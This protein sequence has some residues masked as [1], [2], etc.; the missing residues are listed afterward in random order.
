MSNPPSRIDSGHRI[1]FTNFQVVHGPIVTILIRMT[2]F[3]VRHPLPGSRTRQIC[4]KINIC[5]ESNNFICK[6]W[7]L[8]LDSPRFHEDFPPIRRVSLADH[9]HFL[10]S[11]RRIVLGFVRESSCNSFGHRPIPSGFRTIN[12]GGVRFWH[13]GPARP[14]AARSHEPEGLNFKF[15]AEKP[16][17][18]MPERVPGGFG[19]ME[20]VK[21]GVDG[22]ENRWPFLRATP[23]ARGW[24]IC[25]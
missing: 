8:L 10:D 21:K 25:R 7:K 24:L 14:S 3:R 4:P 20:S 6:R 23:T 1:G 2:C 16:K 5:C 15:P 13:G 22:G 17:R 11:G 12:L 18:G 19:K 9:P